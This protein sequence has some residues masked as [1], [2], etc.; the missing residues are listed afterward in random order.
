MGRLVRAAAGQVSLMALV[1]HVGSRT[2]GHAKA[3]WAKDA[4]AGRWPCTTRLNCCRPCGDT[5][6]LP[7]RTRLGPR[8]LP[9]RCCAGVPQ[10]GDR[11]EGVQNFPDWRRPF[12]AKLEF[13]LRRINRLGD[14]VVAEYMISHSG[15]PWLFTV[16][17]TEIEDDRVAHERVYITEGWEPAEWRAPWRAEQP[18]DPAPPWLSVPPQTKKSS[19]KHPLGVDGITLAI[20]VILLG[21]LG[22]VLA[23]EQT[24]SNSRQ[25]PDDSA[26]QTGEWRRWGSTR[27]ELR[28]RSQPTSPGAKSQVAAT[29]PTRHGTASSAVFESSQPG[30]IEVSMAFP[31]PSPPPRRAGSPRS[32]ASTPSTWP[33]TRSRA[34]TQWSRSTTRCTRAPLTARK[35]EL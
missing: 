2:S 11:F 12:P 15:A 8:D 18:A 23:P 16:S 5:G 17:I 31:G 34:W 20:L 1:S 26:E 10:S 29:S 35:F 25:R 27:P 19:Y 6:S 24:S 3:A 22:S 30:R 13:H 32:P 4:R 28:T 7:A 14:L 21:F 33:A 9:R